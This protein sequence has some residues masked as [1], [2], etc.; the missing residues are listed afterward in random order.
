MRSKAA[1]GFTLVEL[2]VVIGII[3]LLIGILLPALNRARESA[4]QVKCGSNLH[5][6]GIGLNIYISD[7][8]GTLPAS[9]L[10]VGYS[11]TNGVQSPTKPDHG[12]IHWS[13][14]LFKDYSDAKFATGANGLGIA[15]GNPGPYADAQPWGM[16]MCPSLDNGG[17]PPT[18]TVA[19]N[20]DM[21]VGNDVPGYV[22]YQAPR[23]AYTLN[24]VL[25]PRNKFESNMTTS[26]RVC[27]YVRAGSVDNS[28]QTILATEWNPNPLVVN[29]A[30]E[31]SGAPVCKSHRPVNGWTNLGSAGGGY[32][33][34]P[35]ISIGAGLIHVT[36]AM[37]DPNPIDSSAAD[38]NSQTRLDWVGRNHGPKT[39]D[40]KGFDT[41]RTNFLYLDGHVECKNIRDTLTPWQWGQHVYSLNPHTDEL[42]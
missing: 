18:D 21:G 10:Y 13:S 40:S 41:R 12:Y 19:S 37:L 24:E 42:Q 27:Q 26:G 23:L 20:H 11:D 25:C 31:E 38:P 17:L 7:N 34:L 3:A 28:S 4:K 22:D 6:I 35:D 14:Y 2:L 32:V 5:Q 33:D 8:R 30:G 1:R 39:L 9:Y 36:A 29:A 16:F 15:I